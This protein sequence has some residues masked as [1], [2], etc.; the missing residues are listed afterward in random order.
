M[1][2]GL[3]LDGSSVVLSSSGV[4]LYLDAQLEPGIQA[5]VAFLAR[6]AP[7]HGVLPKSDEAQGTGAKGAAKAAWPEKADAQLRQQTPE[8]PPGPHVH[9][10]SEHAPVLPW[11]SLHPS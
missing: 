7:T 11:T 4:K 9:F 6:T 1:T 5:D 2:T 8:K 10:A 3:A